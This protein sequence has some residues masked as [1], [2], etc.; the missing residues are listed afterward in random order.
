MSKIMVVGASGTIGRAVADLF[1]KYNE[2]I[3]VGNQRGD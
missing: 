1:E 3:R 2:L